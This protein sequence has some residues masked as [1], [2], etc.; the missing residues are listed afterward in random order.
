MKPTDITA[1][2]IYLEVQ[3]RQRDKVRRVDVRPNLNP[4][5]TEARLGSDENLVEQVLSA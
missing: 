3:R 5:N 4:S 2:L 1:L